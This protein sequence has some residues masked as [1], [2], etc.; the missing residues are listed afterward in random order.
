MT[1][2][3][4]IARATRTRMCFHL[5]TEAGA[6]SGKFVK[7]TVAATDAD[8]VGHPDSAVDLTALPIAGRIDHARD[9]RT[10]FFYVALHESATTTTAELSQLVHSAAKLE[11]LSWALKSRSG[12][13]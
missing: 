12:G 11:G 1:N 3:H 8:W 10:P 7:W 2:N 9:A 5:A 6:P 13:G 4:L